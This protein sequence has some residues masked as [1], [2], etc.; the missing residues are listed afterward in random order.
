MPP[1]FHGKNYY[2]ALAI[3]SEES[4]SGVEEAFRE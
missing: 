2:F 3:S 1:F 4:L